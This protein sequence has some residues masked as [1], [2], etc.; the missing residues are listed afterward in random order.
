M[1]YSRSLNNFSSN[2]ENIVMGRSN[3]NCYLN[4]YKKNNREIRI[5]M[6]RCCGNVYDYLLRTIKKRILC[7]KRVTNLYCHKKW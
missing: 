1:K 5:Y 3:T 2:L 4:A 7:F 6:F